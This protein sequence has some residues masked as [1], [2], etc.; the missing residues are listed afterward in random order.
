MAIPEGSEITITG[1]GALTPLGASADATWQRL[2]NGDCGVIGLPYIEDKSARYSIGGLIPDFD[3]KEHVRPRKSL[4][5]MGRE[6]QTSFAAS[7]M[8]ISQS[9]LEEY[10]QLHPQFN[11]HRIGTVFGSEMLYGPPAELEDTMRGI[12][13]TDEAESL[14]KFGAA[15]I[16]Q[17]YPLWMLKYLP[18]MAACHVGIAIQA[19]GPNNTILLEDS[20]GPAALIEA[21]S[22]IRRDASDIVICGTTGNWIN[23]SGVVYRGANPMAVPADPVTRSIRPYAADATGVAGGE[24]AASLVLESERLAKRRGVRPLARFAGAAVR[25]APATTR[26]SQQA[27]R[28]AIEAAL[29]DAGCQANDLGLVISH[30]MGDPQQDQ[31]ELKAMQQA[32][33][34]VPVCAPIAATSHCGA[35]TAGFHLTLAVMAIQHR[36]IPPTLNVA[37]LGPDFPQP[38]F[39]SPQPL[40]KPRVMVLTHTAQG[41]AAA[42]IFKA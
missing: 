39:S 17:I 16:R 22:Y 6:L 42:V 1:V 37:D 36:T 23:E 33:P 5:V 19:L 21:V 40:E 9:G 11:R 18:N 32:I 15:A 41:H 13:G 38:I 8:A 28:L 35:A 14:E 29:S 31:A 10:L 20:S 3:P 27:I 30:A 34:G 4:K 2:C 7:M 25:F 26:G 12:S 24:G